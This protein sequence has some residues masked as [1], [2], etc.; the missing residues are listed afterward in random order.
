MRV[1]R[2]GCDLS[3]KSQHRLTTKTED[4]GPATHGPTRVQALRAKYKKTSRGGEAPKDEPADGK[5]LNYKT[6]RPKGPDTNGVSHGPLLCAAPEC[7]SLV[8]NNLGSA[9]PSPIFP[10]PAHLML[11][12][13]PLPWASMDLIGPTLSQQDLSGTS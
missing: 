8:L 11:P 6:V 3:P 5:L 7:Q 13:E 10:Y 1:V 9:A 2:M 4:P 12:P